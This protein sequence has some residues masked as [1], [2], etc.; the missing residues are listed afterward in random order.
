METVRNI[1]QKPLTVVFSLIFFIFFFQWVNSPM[2]ITVTGT[3][4]VSAPAESATVTFTVSVDDQSVSQAVFLTDNRVNSIKESLVSLGIAE[5]SIYESEIATYP[6]N[7]LREGSSGF[8]AVSTMGIK[9]NGTENIEKIIPLLYEKG[10]TLV[11]QPVLSVDDTQKLEADA[12]NLAL[13]DAKKR[14]NAIALKNLKFLKKIVLVEQTQTQPT[15][16]VTTKADVETQVEQNISPE[17]GI[18][19]IQKT[20]SVSYKMW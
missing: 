8:T 11:S 17:A 4:E 10:A 1:F 13:K 5:S 18:I 12:F 19:R 16:T 20:L 7:T 6:T 9:T 3:G 2:I 15:T 14:A